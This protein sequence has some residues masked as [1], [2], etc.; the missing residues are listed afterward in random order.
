MSTKLTSRQR[1]AAALNF[2]PVDRVPVDLNLSYYAYLGLCEVTGFAAPQLPKPG[3]SM[4]VCPDPRLYEQLGVDVYSIKF[5][6]D[7]TFDGTLLETTTDAWGIPYRLVRQQAG[8]LYESIGHPLSDASLADLESYAWPAVPTGAM[9]AALR[10]H[11][12]FLHETTGLALCG[13]FG[14]PIME[15][16]VGLLGFEEWMM[17][18]LDEPE[19]TR[20]LLQK[21]E[22]V[23]TAWDV[24]GIEACGEHLA[25]MKVSGEDFGSQQ[26]LLYSPRTIRDCLLP[27]LSR[28]WDAAH[29]ALQACGSPAKVML[30]TCG[31]VKPI[32]PDLITAGIEVLDPIQPKAADMDPAGLHAAFA[33]RLVF[34]GGIDV[35]EILPKGTAQSVR[36]HVRDVVTALDGMAGG[37]IL[38]PSHAVQADVPPENILAMLED[39]P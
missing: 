12:W 16:A 5:G 33:G 7:A 39:L 3:L 35:Q 2:Q 21:I 15:V 8:A 23:A 32:I 4:E 17:R 30:H 19:F 9:K 37:Y 27:V 13:R 14:A 36:E 18:L 29:A 10:K 34:H 6:C 20:T 25:I 11:A 31:A 38:A 22:A 24:A 28:R 26:S 1:V